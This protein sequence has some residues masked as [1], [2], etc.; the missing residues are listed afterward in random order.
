MY[1]WLRLPFL[2]CRAGEKAQPGG[3]EAVP[4]GPIQSAVRSSRRSGRFR[5]SE[6]KMLATEKG[7]T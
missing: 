3:S 2:E 5:L 1:S 4:A 7:F 6:S